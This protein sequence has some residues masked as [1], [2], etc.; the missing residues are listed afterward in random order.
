MPTTR[1]QSLSRLIQASLMQHASTAPRLN[2]FW[3]Y[4][5]GE[6]ERLAESFARSL[7]GGIGKLP[8]GEVR[9]DS[10]DRQ[11]AKRSLR[12]EISGR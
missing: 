10:E 7:A 4:S 12:K 2:Q 3:L 1:S 6:V 8:F 9:E 11:E 5:A